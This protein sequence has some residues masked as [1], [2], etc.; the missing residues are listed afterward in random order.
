ME[1]WCCIDSI[2]LFT[3]LHFLLVQVFSKLAAGELHETPNHRPVGSQE[4]GQRVCIFIKLNSEAQLGLGTIAPSLY[5]VALHITRDIVG[6]QEM[7]DPSNLSLVTSSCFHFLPSLAPDHLLTLLC[8]PCKTVT[9]N[10]AF[11]FFSIP[12]A[13]LLG[14][15]GKLLQ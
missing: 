12:T 13:R 9:T 1:L 11:L 10:Y 2:F 4:S 3:C 7:S 6:P 15:P 8:F 5:S 14:D